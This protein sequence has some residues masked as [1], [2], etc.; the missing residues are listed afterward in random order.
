MGP[1]KIEFWDENLVKATLREEIDNVSEKLISH[2]F[3]DISALLP[4]TGQPAT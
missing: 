4:V 2:E 1:E 3:V